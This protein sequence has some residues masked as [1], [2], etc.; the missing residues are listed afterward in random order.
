MPCCGL[1]GLFLNEIGIGDPKAVASTVYKLA[2]GLDKG[3]FGQAELDFNVLFVS[4]GELSLAKSLPNARQSQWIRMVDIS[5]VVRPESAF[6]TISNYELHPR[7][8]YAATN[9]CHGTV[10]HDWLQPI[11]SG[12][13]LFLS[14]S[15]LLHAK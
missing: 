13:Y 4:T 6:E 10:G 5:A 11:S 12:L 15:V 1:V 14:I 8:F 7:R 3:R 2:G 9:E